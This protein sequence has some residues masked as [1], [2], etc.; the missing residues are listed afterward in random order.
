V[1]AFASRVW[2][3]ILEIGPGLIALA[4]TPRPRGVASG[5]VG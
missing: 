2:I 4:L 1:L 3:T 5:R